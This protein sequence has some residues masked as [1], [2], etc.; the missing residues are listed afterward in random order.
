VSASYLPLHDPDGVDPMPGSF[1]DAL[2]M[3][4]EYVA[5]VAASNI[6]DHAEMVKAA[7][8]LDYRLRALIVAVDAERGE[9]L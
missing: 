3:A 8:G 2:R 1:A 4:R 9:R 7:S 6:H 5:E